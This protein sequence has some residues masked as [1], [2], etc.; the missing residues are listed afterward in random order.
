MQRAEVQRAPVQKR[1]EMRQG[2]GLV[3]ESP[4]GEQ[5]SQL[6]AMADGSPQVVK[7]AQFAAMADTSPV[8]TAQRR[9]AGMVH[10]SLP[11]STQ[12]KAIAGIH[13][14]PHFTVQRQKM[15]EQDETAQRAEAAAK[16][17]PTGLPDNLKSGVETLSGISMDNVRVSYNSSQPTQLNAL[18]YAQG[19]DIHVAPG[20]EQHLPHEAWHV[21][22]QAQGRV[23]PTMQM[24]DGVPVN[25]DKGLEN[26]AD[27]MGWKAASAGEAAVHGGRGANGDD[28]MLRPTNT[29]GE[30]RQLKGGHLPALGQV[31]NA[32]PNP[33]ESEN[34]QK[35]ANVLESLK[36]YI[37]HYN[38]EI[39]AN[40]FGLQLYMISF[41]KRQIIQW[42][43]MRGDTSEKEGALNK[44]WAFFGSK[45]EARRIAVADLRSAILLEEAHV[46]DQGHQA[47]V[48]QNDQ[49]RVQLGQFVTD[50]LSNANDRLLINSCQWIQS[51]KA[52]LYA[53][54]PTG[55]S[56]AR[57]KANYMDAAAD[58]AFF[59][60]GLPGSPGDVYS[61]PVSYNHRNREDN[62]NVNLSKGG[63]TTGGWNGPGYI[64]I[65]NVST[66]G[67][68]VVWSRIRH[69]VQHDADRH[70]DRDMMAGAH[71]AAENIKYEARDVDFGGLL[72]T[73]QVVLGEE[74]YNAERD[75]QRYKSEYRA[76]SY[77][78]A[79]PAGHFSRLDNTR[80][81][82]KKDGYGFSERQLAIFDH[83]YQ[84]YDYA[85]KQWDDNPV[86]SDGTTM[87]RQAVADYWDPDTEGFN[88]YNSPRVD[89]FYLALD[90][91]GGKAA[92]NR[93][94]TEEQVD[95]A[96][97]SAKETDRAAPSIAKL[98]E[99][100]IS[101]DREDALYLFESSTAMRK[102]LETH[103]DGEALRTVLR[104]LEARAYV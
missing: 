98:I 88:K 55:D 71:I 25:D 79:D 50:G 14:S 100:I 72:L 9:I 102:K 19:T 38:N 27:V 56:Y 62:T 73:E 48:A 24:K 3:V 33:I 97:V 67:R 45:T 64:A 82:K 28:A 46:E 51:G 6:E 49:D 20:Q 93:K 75:L 37:D 68:D 31:E 58:Q 12:R 61:A 54:T 44:A 40:E 99:T 59:P 104:I 11:M 42:E 87:F 81:D 69:E 53:V 90:A 43:S 23:K 84:Q 103:L 39:P 32:K 101:L 15:E 65:A 57:L 30:A 13:C 83:V 7:Q 16:T 17:N 94:E 21:V 86:L 80:Q 34:Q 4:Q 66:V 18:A 8:A 89:D 78:E 26:E 5:I 96:P 36:L 22:Q 92:A 29:W 52:K 47:A 77:Q 85:K 74:V 63:S 76:Y 10:N 70:R 60:Q 1:P 91:I 95:I 2:K 41:M 35:E